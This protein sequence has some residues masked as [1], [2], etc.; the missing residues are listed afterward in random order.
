MV[1]SIAEDNHD[2]PIPTLLMSSTHS[3]HL[4][5][6]DSET[7]VESQRIHQFVTSQSGTV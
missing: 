6:D 4:T 5:A 1:E 7:I 2:G 3:I